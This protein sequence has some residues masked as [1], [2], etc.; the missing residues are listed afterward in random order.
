MRIRCAKLS[1]I[2]SRIKTYLVFL[3]LTDINIQRL[4]I[5]AEQQKKLLDSFKAIENLQIK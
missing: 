3:F 2:L 4:Q 5:K 1:H